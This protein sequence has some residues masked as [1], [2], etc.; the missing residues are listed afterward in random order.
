MSSDA[1][2]P[3]S[4]R[5]MLNRVLLVSSIVSTLRYR[6]GNRFA[7]FERHGERSSTEENQPAKVSARSYTR[8]I[9]F[10]YK[11]QRYRSL[12]K[13][14]TLWHIVY[15]CTFLKPPPLGL[16]GTCHF[17]YRRTPVGRSTVSVVQ[18]EPPKRNRVLHSLGVRVT[19]AVRSEKCRRN[20]NFYANSSHSW[21]L[22][23]V[24]FAIVCACF[25]RVQIFAD[26]SVLSY[27]QI[28][29][30]LNGAIIRSTSVFFN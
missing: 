22:T 9:S 10:V 23:H 6:I 2:R 24:T 20:E 30:P 7:M 13:P 28:S 19:D 1:G 11:F 27:R 12:S 5:K 16:T 14:K 17:Y 21:Y 4:V 25:I 29:R 8:N 15:S 3:K 26:D 18:L